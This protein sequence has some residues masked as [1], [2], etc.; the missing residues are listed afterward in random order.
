MDRVTDFESGGCAFD[1]RRG[2]FLFNMDKERLK[3][4]W[5]LPARLERISADSY[6][7]HHASGIRG[8]LIRMLEKIEHGH[9]VR[10]S[11]LKRLMDLG[12]SVLEKAAE[13][14]SA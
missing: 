1:P 2:H 13:E 5:L 3:L 9:P 7:A 10:S 8:S 11:Q 4:I 12:F 6:W 14:L